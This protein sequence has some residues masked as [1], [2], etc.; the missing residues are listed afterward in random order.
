MIRDH[1]L[2]QHCF[3][4]RMYTRADVVDHIIPYLVDP[5]LGLVE[6]NLQSLCNSCHS[7]K[8]AMDK[9]KYNL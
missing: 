8:T 2:C 3:K 5:S 4:K 9:K 6:S 1:G 7:I